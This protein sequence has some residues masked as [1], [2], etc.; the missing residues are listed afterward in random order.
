MI[1]NKCKDDASVFQCWL[2][3]LIVLSSL[4]QMAVIN[5]RID[6]SQE[7]EEEGSSHI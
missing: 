2:K 3:N 5:I 4:Q 7:E 6:S 1:V